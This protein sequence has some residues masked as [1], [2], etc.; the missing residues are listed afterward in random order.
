M[1]SSSRSE[2]P[3]WITAVTPARATTSSPS[4][5]GK[6]ASDAHTAAAVSGA[7]S[8]A[9]ITARRPEAA[10]VRLDDRSVGRAIAADDPAVDRHRVGR[11]RPNHRRADR[12]AER[13]AARVRVLDDDGRGLVELEQERKGRREVQKVVVAELRPVELFHAPETDR[14]CIDLTVEGRGLVRI[15][16]V[17]QREHLRGVDP[18]RARERGCRRTDRS[19][20]MRLAPLRGEIRG[21]GGVV[22]RGPV[23]RFLREPVARRF[24]DGRATGA[25]LVKDRLIL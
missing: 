22:L 3:G 15:L 1:T 12:A 18:E 24:A 7:S 6:N 14:G 20:R 9:R 10:R 17:A 8:W 13:G 19:E 2:P 23:E 21:D 4:R 5:N 11:L 16:T 25:K